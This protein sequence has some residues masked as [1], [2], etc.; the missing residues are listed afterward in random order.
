MGVLVDFV[1]KRWAMGSFSQGGEKEVIT[2]VFRLTYVEN[3]GAA[4]GLFQNR[5]YVFIIITVIMVCLI[6]A[7]AYKKRKSLFVSL[8]SALVVS[9]ALGNLIDRV[10]LG[11]VIDFIDFCF[12]DFPVFNVADCFVCIGAALLAI[13]FIFIEKDMEND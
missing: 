6:L 4:F 13:Y 5:R 2:N 1:T 7:L 10:F 3:R 9:G 11:Y 8:S 12:I